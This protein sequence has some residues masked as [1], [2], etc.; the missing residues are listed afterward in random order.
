VNCIHIRLSAVFFTER[1]PLSI[2]SESLFASNE[3]AYIIIPCQK[4]HTAGRNLIFGAITD[5]ITA[6]GNKCQ[7]TFLYLFV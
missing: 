5:I 1:C 4:P 2:P 3:A 7:K 6:G